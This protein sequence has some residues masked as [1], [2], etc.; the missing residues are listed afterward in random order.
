MHI[1]VSFEMNFPYCNTDQ[2]LLFVVF[3]LVLHELYFITGEQ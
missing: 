3:D 2:F 1:P